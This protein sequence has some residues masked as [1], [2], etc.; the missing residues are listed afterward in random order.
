LKLFHLFVL[1]IFLTL[2][3]CQKKTIPIKAENS[4]S[5]LALGDS[6]TIGESV[7]TDKRWPVQLAQKLTNDG[8]KINE[9]TIVAKT[10]WTTDELNSAIDKA[11]LN[12]E[13]DLVSLLI[14]V[15]NQYRGKPVGEFKPEFSALIDRAIGFAGGDIKKVF[16][17]SI[18]DYG[19]TPFAKSRNP[20]KISFEIDEYNEASK[21]ICEQKGVTY[22]DITPISREATNKP[23]YVASDGLHPSGD[24]YTA[25]VN[26]IT[27][28]ILQKLY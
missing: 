2:A 23:N 11:N 20:M 15:N 26:K 4:V 18:P 14:G 7:E 27:P 8:F 3:S 24:M 12:D 17:V 16:V 25:W 1:G 19:V 10:G 13:Y 21:V 9:P 28:I 22:I 6:Y 5:Y